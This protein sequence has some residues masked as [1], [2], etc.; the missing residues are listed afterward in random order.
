MNAH[1][2]HACLQRP[3]NDIVFMSLVHPKHQTYYSKLLAIVS[4]LLQGLEHYDR[5]A[6]PDTGCPLQTVTVLV[7]SR[8][9]HP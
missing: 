3:L 9:R 1:L 5:G 4:T 2:H 7:E 8:K 6:A